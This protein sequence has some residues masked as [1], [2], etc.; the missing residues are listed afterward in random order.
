MPAAVVMPE[1]AVNEYHL[2]AACEYEIWFA[3]QTT[4][5]QPKAVP[6][7]VR[8]LTYGYFRVRVPAFYSP[9]ISAATIGGQIIHQSP[10]FLRSQ[11]YTARCSSI[12][13]RLT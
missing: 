7:T 4:D 11:S 12:P 9:H 1:A 3:R 8:Y 13:A 6:Q 10:N 5:V 2:M